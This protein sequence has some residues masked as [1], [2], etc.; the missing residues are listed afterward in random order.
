M[1][2]PRDRPYRHRG[3][4]IPFVE[5]DENNQWSS[6]DSIQADGFLFVN[7]LAYRLSHV[8]S[9]RTGDLFVNKVIRPGN[10]TLWIHFGS[11]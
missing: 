11:C 9:V 8:Q 7:D 3:V 6:D 2:A 4:H 1:A 5:A 10:N